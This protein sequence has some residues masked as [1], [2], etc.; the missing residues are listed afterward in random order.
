M[1][2]HT[3]KVYE[4]ELRML[5]EKILLIAERVQEIINNSILALEKNDIALAKSTIEY[6]KYIDR[7]ELLIDDQCI[8]MLAKRQPL[9]TDLRLIVSV[10]KMVTDFERLGD[11]AVNICER[12]IKL[13]NPP[14]DLDIDNLKKMA[15]LVQE[16]IKNTIAAF[17]HKDTK[18]AKSI[19]KD[20]D[21]IDELYHNT[22]QDYINE[23]SKPKVDGAYIF[24]LLSIA[25]WLERMG[26]HC[27][28][29]AELIIYMINGEDIR[30][31]LINVKADN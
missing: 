22:M 6:D 27:T 11:L 25:K 29:L 4:N 5:E 18:K 23:L 20:D 28:N 17:F 16:M 8:S 9:G 14:K 1:K 13:K 10:L 3:N 24:H 30:H 2:T 31:S 21:V 7:E 19:I 15:Y 26:D 12:V